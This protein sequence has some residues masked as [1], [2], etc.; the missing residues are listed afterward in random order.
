M[1]RTALLNVMVNAVL[2]AGRGLAR[3]FGEVENLQV[4]LKGPGD[5]VSAADRRA[6][7]TLIAELRK[8]R[9]GYSFLAEESGVTEG[10]DNVHRWIIDPLDGTTN[11]LHGNPIFAISVGLEREGTMVAGVIYNPIL[12]ELYVAERGSGAFLNDR[13]LR[14][15]NRSHLADCVIASGIPQ[16]NRPGQ[17]EYLKEL[18]TVIGQVAGVRCNGSAAMDLAWTASGRFDGYWQRGLSPWDVAGGIVIAREAGVM[19]SDQAGGE[20]VLESGSILAA[21]ETIHRRMIEL[22]DASR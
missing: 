18:S 21:N 9:P 7:E 1:A 15:A 12:N 20:N 16:L 2:K 3:D 6:E 14:V 10:S 4:S 19:V 22:L 17:P 11:F 13:R 8:A 5:F